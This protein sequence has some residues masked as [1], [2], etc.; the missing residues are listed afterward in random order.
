MIE[1]KFDI[2]QQI[3]NVARTMVEAK[4]P[5]LSL[6]IKVDLSRTYVA[7]DFDHIFEQELKPVAYLAS[8]IAEEYYSIKYKEESKESK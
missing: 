2:E 1:T 7:F 3:K 5:I 4:D 8:R 6:R